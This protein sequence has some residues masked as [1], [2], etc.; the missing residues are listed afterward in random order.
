MQAPT[1]I[2]YYVTLVIMTVALIW[3]LSIIA[4]AL[5]TPGGIPIVDEADD[6]IAV[7]RASRPLV[8]TVLAEEPDPNT[9]EIKGSFS[10][11][12]G[13]FGAAG[14]A[15]TVIGTGYWVVFALFWLPAAELGRL[16]SL[17]FY[18]L[19]ASAL[20]APYAFNQLSKLFRG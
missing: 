7:T 2:T 6:A 10:R 4:R 15:A 11:T 1:Q 16:Q 13:A 18:F 19:G 5:R 17:G 12:A 20:F 8:A 3:A 9:G 14:I